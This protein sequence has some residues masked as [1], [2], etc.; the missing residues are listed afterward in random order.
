MNSTKATSTPALKVSP[1]TSQPPTPNTSV[2]PPG[3]GPDEVNPRKN[4][5][6]SLGGTDVGVEKGTVEIVKV[7]ETALLTVETACHTH[8]WQR[9]TR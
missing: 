7:P 8:A 9:S 1:I 4:M 3:K 5:A 6:D 2:T